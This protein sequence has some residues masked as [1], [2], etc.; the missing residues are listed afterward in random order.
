MRV[1]SFLFAVAITLLLSAP[2]VLAQT[3][4]APPSGDHMVKLTNSAKMN[5]SAVYVA[6]AGSL[7]MSDDLLGKQVAAAGKT[8]TLKVKDPAASCVFD[9]RFLMNDGST[10]TRS[11]VD[12]CHNPD[13]T[14]SPGG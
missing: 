8:V 11:N 13:Y 3:N 7:D 2:A 10:V 9:V 14:F 12:L 1:S 6:A 4:A 5:I